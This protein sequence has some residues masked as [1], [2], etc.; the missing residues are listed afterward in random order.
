MNTESLMIEGDNDILKLLRQA[1]DALA[2]A[3]SLEDYRNV[4][5]SAEAIRVLGENARAGLDVRNRVAELRL[6]AERGAG[7]VLRSMALRGGDRRTKTQQSRL[8]LSDLGITSNEPECLVQRPFLPADDG[9]M[10]ECISVSGLDPQCV[11][12]RNL[13]FIQVA[14]FKLD[15]SQVGPRIRVIRPNR[16]SPFK[17][18]LRIL[19]GVS[20]L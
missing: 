8:T 9:Q 4:R 2:G 7:D 20:G 6:R 18:A 15:E 11:T 13:R 10:P 5:D 17:S 14:R 19:A 3:E 12:E 16:D 1:F